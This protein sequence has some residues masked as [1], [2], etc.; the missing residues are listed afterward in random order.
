M[1]YSTKEIR[2]VLENKTMKIDRKQHPILTFGDMDSFINQL[3]SL[4]VD[5]LINAMENLVVRKQTLE[6]LRTQLVEAE[7]KTNENY[8]EVKKT[9]RT[10]MDIMNEIEEIKEKL[11][12]LS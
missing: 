7:K 4:E 11:N 10:N 6:Q 2:N 3:T 5:A 12:L 8:E 9:H 1:G